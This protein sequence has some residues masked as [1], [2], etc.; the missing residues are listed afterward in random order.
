MSCSE[1]CHRTFGG[2]TEFD[3]HRRAGTCRDPEDLGHTPDPKGVF[4]LPSPPGSYGW[5]VNTRSVR[6]SEP[7]TA[8][9]A[10]GVHPVGDGDSDA[11]ETR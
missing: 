1:T 5:F 8:E 2:I 9:Q 4:R 7:E 3:A 10:A 6:P 11:A